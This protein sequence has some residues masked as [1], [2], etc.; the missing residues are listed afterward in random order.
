M[1][2]QGV[3]FDF[4]YTL[5]DSTIPI[6]IGYRKGFEAL[7]WPAPTVEQVRGTIGM[8]LANGYELLTGDRDE[9]KKTAFYHLFRAA[10]GEEAGGTGDLRVMVEETRLLPGAVELLEALKARAVP[11]AIVSTKPRM[12]IERI[13]E[14]R[15]I[16]HLQ[17]L[18]VGD[19]DVTRYKPDP[20]GLNFALDRLG[21]K[22]ERVLFCGDT[23]IDA[24]AARNAGV[25]FCAVLNGTTP[26]EAFGDYP[27][28]HISEDL[29]DL[30]RWLEL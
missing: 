8:T 27:C 29:R 21:L 30:Y 22:R 26:R 24:A 6:A 23:V 19:E 10:V 7:G 25:D 9:A 11:V 13:F 12:T 14:Y 4:D 3:F 17:D 1:N 16:T 5:G 15:G 18:I 20:E 28:V 2:Y